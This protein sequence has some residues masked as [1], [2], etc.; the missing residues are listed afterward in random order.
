MP[1][2]VTIELEGDEDPSNNS[3]DAL[4]QVTV[5]EPFLPFTGSDALRL[6]ILAMLLLV[7]GVVLRRLSF[8]RVRS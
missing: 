2:I 6:A 8:L 4:V 5:G 7:A 1:N 3:D